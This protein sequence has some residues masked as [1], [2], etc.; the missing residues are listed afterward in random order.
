MLFLSE[1][2]LGNAH[3]QRHLQLQQLINE[4]E[5]VAKSGLTVQQKRDLPVTI[6]KCCK[7]K[8]YERVPFNVQ[9]TARASFWATGEYEKQNIALSALMVRKAPKV[10]VRNATSH[11][12][13]I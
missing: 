1:T 7:K 9:R 11:K 6:E 2:W 10:S 13:C 3:L 5:G 8:C 4:S 12:S